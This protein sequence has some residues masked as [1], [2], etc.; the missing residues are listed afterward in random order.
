MRERP[1]DCVC[2]RE[3]ANRSLFLLLTTRGVPGRRQQISKAI[4]LGPD[5]LDKLLGAGKA[6]V[7]GWQPLRV[8][9]RD[10]HARVNGG[11]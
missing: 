6:A 11:S 8:A 5:C 4:F 10:V 2:G 7:G 3:P 1:N 9:L